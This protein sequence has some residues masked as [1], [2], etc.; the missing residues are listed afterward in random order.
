[1][2]SDVA[3]TL[4]ALEEQLLDPAVR[5]SRESVAALIS[6]DFV[7]IG[8]SGRVY[9]KAQVVEG[10]AQE[11]FASQTK[12]SAYD[13]QCRM[14]TDGVALLTYKALHVEASVETRTLRSSIW[15]L[16]HGRWQ[17]V[18]HQGTPSPNK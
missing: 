11:R 16:E 17:L 5:Q 13:F 7:E 1:M 4:K 6:D 2:T 12:R 14:L 8:A 10:L 9:D 15:K 18:F 3:A